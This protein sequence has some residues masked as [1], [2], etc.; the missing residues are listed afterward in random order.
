MR[1][2]DQIQTGGNEYAFESTG[3]NFCKYTVVLAVIWAMLGGYTIAL[4][5]TWAMLWSIR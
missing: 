4:A 5:V 3:W 1:D 2:K